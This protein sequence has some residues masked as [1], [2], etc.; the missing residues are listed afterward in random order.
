MKRNR[1]IAASLVVLAMTAASC[2]DSGGSKAL[3]EDD[4]ISEMNSVCRTASRALGKLDLSDPKAVGDVGNVI[5]DG[6]DSLNKL[7]PPKGLKADFQDFTANLDDQLTQITK[8]DKA[9]KKHDA[10]AA[11][12]ASDKLTKLS[13]ASDDLAGSI[14]AQRCVGVASG[15]QESS[16]TSTPVTDP[17]ES[18]QPTTSETSPPT[19]D[20]PTLNTPLPIDTSPVTTASP[21]Q[22]T[23][24]TPSGLLVAEDAS[25]FFTPI[26]GYKWGSFDF[27]K[28]ATP[29]DPVL[30]A[31][32]G[33]YI[34]GVMVSDKDGTRAEVYVTILNADQPWTAAQLEAY[35]NFEVAGTPATTPTLS[36]PGQLLESDVVSAGAFTSNGFGVAIFTAP[37][38]DVATLVD[39]FIVAQNAGM[40]GG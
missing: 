11:Q 28:V 35:H 20:A 40:M 9:V 26:A 3:S 14:G 12:T 34:V 24:A 7:S 29:N 23:Q 19:T 25:Q 6:L 1:V 15:L 4:F 31:S 10:N 39:D 18:T 5:Q 8:L 36:L 16:T 37:G 33:K 17:V 21:T 32:V 13:K 2:G 22:S 38:T 30:S 27:A